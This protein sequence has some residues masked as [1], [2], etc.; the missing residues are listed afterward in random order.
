VNHGIEN[1]DDFLI[2]DKLQPAWAKRTQ[3]L[4]LAL[5]RPLTVKSLKGLFFFY[6]NTLKVC[7]QETV[8]STVQATK[9]LFS[10]PFQHSEAVGRR[11]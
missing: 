1:D 8:T 7:R 6:W 3:E 4:M 2:N 5:E 9:I 11:E 10:T